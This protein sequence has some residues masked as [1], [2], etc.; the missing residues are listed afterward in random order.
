M[1]Q[2]LETLSLSAIIGLLFCS[3]LIASWNLCV[4]CAEKRCMQMAIAIKKSTQRD[5]HS[6]FPLARY[7]T[8]SNS[9][10]KFKGNECFACTSSAA[11]QSSLYIYCEINVHTYAGQLPWD[12][13]CS[14]R[15]TT[16]R[17]VCCDKLLLS[18]KT[19]CARQPASQRATEWEQKRGISYKF[20]AM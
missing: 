15:R 8:S 20:V 12:W 9:K 11:A 14:E 17:P 13:T 16:P 18:N 2:V 4:C 1:M 6:L 3:S 19:Q 7:A 5:I 10:Y